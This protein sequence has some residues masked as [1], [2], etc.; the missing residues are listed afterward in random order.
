MNAKPSSD[1]ELHEMIMTRQ[2][3]RSREEWQSLVD[4]ANEAFD[5]QEAAER[6]YTRIVSHVK[7]KTIS[8]RSHKVTKVLAG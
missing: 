2:A 6:V 3:G 4:A 1:A 7:P 8:K 5:H